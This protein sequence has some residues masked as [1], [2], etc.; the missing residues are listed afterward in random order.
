M[1]AIHGFTQP[2]LML[3]NI[4]QYTAGLDLR[5]GPIIET[6]AKLGVEGGPMNPHL[7]A[8]LPSQKALQLGLEAFVARGLEGKALQEAIVKLLSVGNQLII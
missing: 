8:L 4:L 7:G 6:A 3:T 5:P 1:V 2:F